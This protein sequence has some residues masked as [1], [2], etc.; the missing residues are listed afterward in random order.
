MRR[1][2]GSDQ[3]QLWKGVEAALEFIYDRFGLSKNIK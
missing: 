2:S 1:Q 3:W